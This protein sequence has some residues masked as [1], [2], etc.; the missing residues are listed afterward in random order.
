MFGTRFTRLTRALQNTSPDL[1][2]ERAAA[3]MPDWSGGTRI[4]WAL[5]EFLDR[6]GGGAWLRAPSC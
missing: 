4:G 6:H 5:G 3:L 1:A 2:L